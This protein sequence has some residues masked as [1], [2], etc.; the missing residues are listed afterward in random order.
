M[1]KIIMFLLAGISILSVSCQ[2]VFTYS[3]FTFLQRDISTRPAAEQ[4]SRAREALSSG[5]REQMA[6][7]YAVVEALL[8]ESD[9][10]ELYLLAAD[11]AFGASGMTEVF[12][13]ALQDLDTITAGST[14][15]FE[16]VLESLDLDLIA[17][18]ASHVQAAEAAGA[19]IS[20][21][22]YQIA[23]AAL[24]ASAVEKAGGFEEVGLLT[25]GQEGYQEFQ[26]AQAYFTAG[27]A[28]DLLDMFDL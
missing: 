21:T 23:G 22:Q 26:D 16:A 18:G 13:Q 5:N 4:I 27:G 2:A 19:E 1:K 3:P 10:P 17:D 20:D 11:L 6:D 25:V 14:E 28:A 7:A 8:E 15:E 9:E 24:L 12:T